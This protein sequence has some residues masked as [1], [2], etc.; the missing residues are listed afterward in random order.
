MNS[1]T[2]AA[3]SM[4]ACAALCGLCCLMQM[5]A[6]RTLQRAKCTMRP[7]PQL[8]QFPKFHQYEQVPM[9]VVDSTGAT[10]TILSRQ[11]GFHHGE[12]IESLDG[13]H[14]LAYYHDKTGK[15]ELIH[16][17]PCRGCAELEWQ[18]KRQAMTNEVA[19]AQSH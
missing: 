14:E 11:F 17:K 7:Q 16:I 12:L 18:A 15:M 2:V 4:A 9:V 10:H 6:T 3:M 5:N 8:S 1:N 13:G 19:K